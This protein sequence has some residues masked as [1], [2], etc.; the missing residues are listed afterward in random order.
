MI[1]V[2]GD[3][4]VS[5]TYFGK[6][7]FLYLS[8]FSKSHPLFTDTTTPFRFTGFVVLVQNIIHKSENFLVDMPSGKF[9]WTWYELCEKWENSREK[10]E[11]RGILKHNLTSTLLEERIRVS[12]L[13]SAYIQNLYEI[14]FSCN[15]E[16]YVRFRLFSIQMWLHRF[17]IFFGRM[18]AK[19]TNIKLMCFDC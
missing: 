8:I 2:T 3:S 13:R 4:R 7:L 18:K 10:M 17:D 11:F 19:K 14:G 6:L 5:T 12:I 15:I 1:L 9:N 16:E